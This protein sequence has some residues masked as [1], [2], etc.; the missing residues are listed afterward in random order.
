[1]T[2]R[3]QLTP[4][5]YALVEGLLQTLLWIMEILA[6][7]QATVGR[8]RDALFGSQS[9][10]TAKL[11]PEPA[12]PADPNQAPPP[13]PK[14]TGHGRRGTTAYPGARRVPVP[15]PLCRAGRLCW[16]C[17]KGKLYP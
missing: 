7:K 2:L 5:A 9:E 12:Q 15:H 11:F 13:K 10:Q 3:P 6:Q 4:E 8:L 1:L 16:E 14:R 17:L